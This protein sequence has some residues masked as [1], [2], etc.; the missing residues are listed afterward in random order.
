MSHNYWSKPYTS[1][2][3]PEQPNNFSSRLPK[4]DN[5]MLYENVEPVGN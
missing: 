3:D 4:E 1:S 2:S 5:T